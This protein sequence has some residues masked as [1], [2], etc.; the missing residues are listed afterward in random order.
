MPKAR[1]LITL[2]KAKTLVNQYKEI[3]PGFKLCITCYKQ[4]KK[5]YFTL[6][7][8]MEQSSGTSETDGSEFATTENDNAVDM[9]NSSLLQQT[10]SPIKLHS[11][12]QRQKVKQAKQK[13]SKAAQNLQTSFSSVCI[14]VSPVKV[15]VVK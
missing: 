7:T 14:S 15:K 5:E 2:A 9:L 6:L 1:H 8:Q 10:I 3:T 12:P 13:L 11:Q 4:A